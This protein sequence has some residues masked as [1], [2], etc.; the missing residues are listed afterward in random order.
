[1]AR[2][3]PAVVL[4][5]AAFILETLW[6]GS[7]QQGCPLGSVADGPVDWARAE[8]LAVQEAEA[9]SLAAAFREQQVL[10]NALDDIDSALFGEDS[11]GG[12]GAR[13][14]PEPPAPLKM[15]LSYQLGQLYNTGRADEARFLKET[16]MPRVAGEIARRLQVKK[17]A[18]KPMKLLH[19][20]DSTIVSA[21]VNG[22]P[23]GSPSRG[24]L[25]LSQTFCFSFM[26]SADF[27]G[28]P[29]M[30]IR[31]NPDF[32]HEF[33]SCNDA[34]V[35]QLVR[36]QGVDADFILYVTSR[37]TGCLS[38]QYVAFS[39]P[40]YLDT[41]DSRPLAAYVNFCPEFVKEESLDMLV[42]TGV[43]EVL[44]TLYF[45]DALFG[46]YVDN[47]GKPLGRD[48]VVRYVTDTQLEVVSPKAVEKARE[49]FGCNTLGGV[50]LEDQGGCGTSTS[51]WDARYLQGEVMTGQGSDET[52]FSRSVWT[53]ITMG[54]AEDS[55]WYLPIYEQAQAL[56]FGRNEGC[57]FISDTCW[58]L[59]SQDN[60][61]F[62][63]GTQRGCTPDRLATARCMEMPFGNKCRSMLPFNG[64]ASDC[65]NPTVE[66]PFNFLAHGAFSRCLEAEALGGQQ[67]VD[68][69]AC[70][71]GACINGEYHIVIGGGSFR[72]PPGGY[73]DIAQSTREGALL[74][75]GPCP[76]SEEIC[77][78]LSCP[79]DC[80][81][82]G[83]C[84]DGAC[85]CF[86]GYTGWD[87]SSGACFAGSCG[88]GFVCDLESGA[89]EAVDPS[90]TP[91]P[92]EIGLPIPGFDGNNGPRGYDGTATASVV[93]VTDI[94]SADVI[95]VEAAAES[96]NME[97][98]ADPGT[99][100]AG[101]ATRK[102]NSLFLI[103][104]P[105]G[106]LAL[107]MLL[108]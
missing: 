79:A 80:S 55:G 82:N 105:L 45:N 5:A 78:S 23:S 51:H 18:K 63:R 42:D 21:V 97:Y 6:M 33:R 89:C 71:R 100:S 1:M 67:L 40:C 19:P 81:T 101:V 108:P 35:C 20:C 34:G 15:E 11:G 4:L 16:V 48:Q 9:A 47:D 76:P 41:T 93:D 2:R 10:R 39:S 77:P 26:A 92:A 56:P 44:H 28:S 57:E 3:T 13:A 46:K 49:H 17:P 91:D 106:L 62:C 90:A 68:G 37:Q 72:C 52:A 104:L 73:L 70:L 29:E 95:V 54:L 65:L 59:A 74:R 96:E 25:E 36:G 60:E 31:H 32:F 58:A 43:H 85:Q 94:I 8:D 24:S 53:A 102:G 30:G 61:F 69:G 50:R 83:R 107:A 38:G 22:N 66:P 88:D 75:I 14:K 98:G 84:I 86:L 99:T 103:V 87:C 27:C 64:T 12:S 7:A